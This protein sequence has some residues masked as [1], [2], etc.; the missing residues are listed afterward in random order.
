MNDAEFEAQKARLEPVVEA[1]VT[2][3][4]LRE[5]LQDLRITY[6]RDGDA[7]SEDG[8]S[9]ALGL[10]STQWEYKRAQVRF[11]LARITDEDDETLP[12]IVLHEFMHIFLQQMVDGFSEDG[13]ITEIAG[14][15]VERT[16]TDLAQA[17]Q[18]V[19]AKESA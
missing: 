9:D 8:Y 3:L 17:F 18:W 15:H 12:Y 14:K 4:H 2:N 5:S 13:K 19:T 11:N 7:M 10:T 1:W 16:A 6:Y